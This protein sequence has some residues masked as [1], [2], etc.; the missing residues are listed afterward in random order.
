VVINSLSSSN[1]KSDKHWK[2]MQFIGSLL[3]ELHVKRKRADYDDILSN[4]Q[5]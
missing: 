3:G 1:K 4:P 5:L 2:K